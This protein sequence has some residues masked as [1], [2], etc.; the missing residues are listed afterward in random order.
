MILQLALLILV[1]HQE[2]TELS[3][4]TSPPLNLATIVR[5][6]T[7][8]DDVH[9][10]VPTFSIYRVAL[11]SRTPTVC[12]RDVCTQICHVHHRACNV[13]TCTLRSDSSAVDGVELGHGLRHLILA[14]DSEQLL[15][16]VPHDFRHA[17]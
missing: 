2:Q 13:C 11:S 3:V 15:L 14:H 4:T 9:V 8:T 1:V 12:W 7:Q 16:N 6:R 10:A 17:S 5:C